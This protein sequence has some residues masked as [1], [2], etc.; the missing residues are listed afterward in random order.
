MVP[1]IV[2]QL[3]EHPASLLERESALLDTLVHFVERYAQTTPPTPPEEREP[4][5]VARARE[6]LEAHYAAEVRLADLSR[7]TGLTPYHLNRVFR[8]TLET[9]LSVEILERFRKEEPYA[10]VRLMDEWEQAKCN[11]RPGD[12]MTFVRPTLRRPVCALSSME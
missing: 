10:H 9:R 11:Y 8:R 4:G 2:H 5:A 1:P 12:T 3:F 6:Y 7:L